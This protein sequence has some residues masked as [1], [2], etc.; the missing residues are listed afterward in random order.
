M[1]DM[2]LALLHTKNRLKTCKQES[3]LCLYIL[4]SSKIDRVKII[5][6]RVIQDTFGGCVLTKM[7]SRLGVALNSLWT[8]ELFSQDT[9]PFV[10]RMS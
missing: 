6:K 7:E 8:A 2:K 1:Y 5:K 4:Y 10:S 3:P 9:I